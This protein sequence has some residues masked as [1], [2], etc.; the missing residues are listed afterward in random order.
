MLPAQDKNGDLPPG[1][2]PATWA[3]VTERFGT[4]SETRIRALS[5]LRHLHEL[6]VRTG[7]LK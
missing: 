3:E 1:I 4:H 5:R 7:K 2:Y 6:A